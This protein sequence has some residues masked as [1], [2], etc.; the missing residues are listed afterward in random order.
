MEPTNNALGRLCENIRINEIENKVI[1]YEGVASNDTGTE[2]ISVIEG[3]EEYSSIGG[4]N[5]PSVSNIKSTEYEV[6]SSTI[7][8]LVENFSLDPGFIKV[9]VE[10][11]ENLIFDGCKTRYQNIDQ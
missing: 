8:D 2:K 3:K 10:G 4:I 9:D 11:A 5:H 6:Q 7:D 1:V